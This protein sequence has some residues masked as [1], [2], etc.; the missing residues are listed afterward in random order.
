AFALYTYLDLVLFGGGV[1]WVINDRRRAALGRARMHGAEMERITAE[2]RGTEPAL[3]G[4]RA[5]VEPQFLF[6]TLAQ[7]KQLYERDAPVGEQMLDELIAYL[8]AAMPKMRDTSSTVGQEVELARAYLAIVKVRLGERFTYEI[9]SSPAVA[10]ERMPPMMLLPL[11]D[12][13][14]ARVLGDSRAAPSP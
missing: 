9:E 11:L 3:R 2:K 13:A 7:V 1:V 4:M 8:R 5:R 10:D 6:N 14:L 12:H